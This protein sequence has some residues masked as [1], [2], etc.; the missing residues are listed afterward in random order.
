M[1]ID[2]RDVSSTLRFMDDRALQQYAAM[3][4]NDPYIFPLAFQESQNRQR[5][6]MNQ[7]AAQGMQQQPKVNEQALAQMAPPQAQ[8]MPEDQ[9]IGGLGAPNMETMADGGIAGYPD[10]DFVT[11]NQSV[12]M[13]A[14]GGHVPRYQGN[15]QD[16]SVV[17]ARGPYGQ[18]P[19]SMAGDIPGFVA[20]TSIFQTQPSVDS[21]EPL[22]RRL[23]RER[24]EAVEVQRV[25]EAR[26]RAAKGQ[27]LSAEDQARIS[28]ADTA[29]TAA[30][31]SAQ[32]LAQFDAASN[33]YMTERAG[34]Q[35]AAKPAP[36]TDAAPK[37]DTTRR[38]ITDPSATRKEP[39]QAT[40]DVMGM[41][42][43]ALKTADEKP[44][45]LEARLKEI[46][47]EKVKAGEE[48]VAGIEAIQKK[49]DDIYKGKKERLSNKEGEI[50]KMDKQ[51]LGL[52]AVLAGARMM[53]TRG[54][55][56]Q[57]I[58]AGIETGSAQ[59]IA[60]QDKINA[61]KDKLSDARDRLE[62][63][64]A[65][66]GEMSAR[67]LHKARNEVKALTT[68]GMENLVQAAMAERKMNRTE[69]VEFVKSQLAVSTADKDRASRERISANE[70]TAQNARAA[71]PT[72]ADRTAM[73]LGTGKT[74]AERLESGMLRLQTITADK[75]G[76]AAVKVLADIN[77]KRQ[78]GEAPVTMEQLLIGAREFS[79][80]MYGP[81]VADVAPT[82]D[83]PR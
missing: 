68:A 79:S 28:K 10:D 58:G 22:F 63:L 27:P 15:P 69:A 18:P 44:N 42:N 11:R 64:E 46:N 45:P 59:Y 41:F 34:K 7:Q 21:E 12:V 61:A 35:A 14:G 57:A 40:T 70:I 52:A 36:K 2:Q 38:N 54:S 37:A 62:E 5:L 80:L 19:A 55:I 53:Q 77:A 23:L 16:G 4:K 81:K 13:M 24:Q 60:G 17:R 43:Q 1:A 66:R 6:R 49:F 20:G 78:P 74:D 73:M 29:K 32:D 67:E 9:G 72:G 33:L 26:A 31:T 3:H 48:N 39:A 76:M 75:S 51:V 65:Q 47:A 30:D 71:M 50:A 83:R 56:G 25:Q 82:R 8:P